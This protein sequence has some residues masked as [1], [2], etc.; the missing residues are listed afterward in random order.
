LHAKPPTI[1]QENPC[2]RR[3]LTTAL[4]AVYT[5]EYWASSENR[6]VRSIRYCECQFRMGQRV[7]GK[8]YLLFGL[9]IVESCGVS[10]SVIR[11]VQRLIH[12]AAPLTSG[13]LSLADMD[14][15]GSNIRC[16]LGC[17]TP[18]NKLTRRFPEFPAIKESDWQVQ[19]CRYASNVHWMVHCS[20]AQIPRKFASAH[21]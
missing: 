8:R 5:W 16:H 9:Q 20:C 15:T 3:I 1:A 7:G 19:W 17:F 18:V 6:L 14:M 10:S 2:W 4:A 13:P 11:F 21:D 12:E